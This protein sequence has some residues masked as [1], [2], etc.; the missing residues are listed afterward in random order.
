MVLQV[1]DSEEYWQ[2]RA[3]KRWTNCQAGATTA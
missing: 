1:I 2:R 3:T